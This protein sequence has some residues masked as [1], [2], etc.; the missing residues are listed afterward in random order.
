LFVNAERLNGGCCDCTEYKEIRI[1][2]SQFELNHDSGIYKIFRDNPTIL[3][4][5]KY[6]F[7]K[8]KLIRIKANCRQWA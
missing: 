5:V 6:P 1:E 4:G 3:K 8:A 2:N 7:F